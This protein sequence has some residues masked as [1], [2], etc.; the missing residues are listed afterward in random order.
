MSS[1]NIAPKSIHCT[2][3]FLRIETRN[4]SSEGDSPFVYHDCAF[5]VH[6]QIDLKGLVLK[7]TLNYVVGQASPSVPMHVVQ[8]DRLQLKGTACIVT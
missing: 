3:S 1:T 7:Q 4:G 2:L 5:E 6:A 8:V